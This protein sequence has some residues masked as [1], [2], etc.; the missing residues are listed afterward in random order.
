MTIP[1][2][3]TRKG[4]YLG[5]EITSAI[6]HKDY[7]VKRAKSNEYLI[8]DC[9]FVHYPIRGEKRWTSIVSCSPDALGLPTKTKMY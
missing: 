3:Q 2:L 8:E 7:K 9:A 5:K 4:D 6:M 1:V